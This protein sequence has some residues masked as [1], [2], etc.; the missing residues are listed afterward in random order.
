MDG[1]VREKR[2]QNLM[3]K[4]KYSKK[5]KVNKIWKEEKE[6]KE[7]KEWRRNLPI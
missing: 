3:T 6:R 1:L 5:M 4:A 2:T 7:E